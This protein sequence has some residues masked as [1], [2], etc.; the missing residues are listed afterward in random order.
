MEGDPVPDAVALTVGARCVAVAGALRETLPPLEEAQGDEGGE[1]DAVCVP[2]TALAEALPRG[3]RDVDAEADGE[4]L[5]HEEALAELLPEAL[6]EG[7]GVGGAV[8]SAEGVAAAERVSEGARRT[9]EAFRALPSPPPPSS[10]RRCAI[11][12]T[13]GPGAPAGSGSAASGEKKPPSSAAA[14]QG[15]SPSSGVTVKRL[16]SAPGPQWPLPSRSEMVA[17]AGPSIA[18]RGAPAG[19]PARDSCASLRPPVGSMRAT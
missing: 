15:P 4:R 16:A 17:R 1:G 8:G 13:S 6:L 11:A 3:E 14:S 10:P 12:S 19:A 2:A 7:E 9:R 5:S 18:P